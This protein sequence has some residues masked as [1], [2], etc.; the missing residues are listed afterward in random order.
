MQIKRSEG[1]RA[2]TR[3]S[4]NKENIGFEENS[5]VV[6]LKNIKVKVEHLYETHFPK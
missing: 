4:F 2:P 6:K 5:K 3:L 1:K